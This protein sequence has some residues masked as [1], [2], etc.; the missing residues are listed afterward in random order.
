MCRLESPRSGESGHVEIDALGEGVLSGTGDVRHPDTLGVWAAGA[1]GRSPAEATS[2]S[3]TTSS[4]ASMISFPDRTPD[5]PGVR[6]C[7]RRRRP[8]WAPPLR[9]GWWAPRPRWPRWWPTRPRQGRRVDA[10]ILDLGGVE[11]GQG[12]GT[13]WTIC[14]APRESVDRGDDLDRPGC[15][16]S[17]SISSP[18]RPC[19]SRSSPSLSRVRST[20][21]TSSSLGHVVVAVGLI[22]HVPVS[23][24]ASRSGSPRL[25]VS[26]FRADVPETINRGRRQHRRPGTPA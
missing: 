7:P 10:Q 26:S 9:S 16:R 13:A 12:H 14:C 18:S 23:P 2:A 21:S 20:T 19:R 17:S 6:W 5:P 8:G 25:R 4:A 22:A 15:A 11:G 1:T 24:V 3:A